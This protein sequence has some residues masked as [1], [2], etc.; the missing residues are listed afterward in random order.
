ME[1]SARTT[2]IGRGLAVL[3][4]AA[5][6]AL[7][8]EQ[9]GSPLAAALREGRPCLGWLA[10]ERPGTGKPPALVLAVYQPLRRSLDLVYIP[11]DIRTEAGRTLDQVYAAALKEGGPDAA[12]RMADSAGTFLAPA[13][14][15]WKDWQGLPL[16]SGDCPGSCSEPPL[17]ARDWLLVRMGA[18]TWP[19]LLRTARPG[20]RAASPW[21]R[22]DRLLLA[23]ELSRLKPASL[24]PA[25]LPAQERLGAL[26][27]RCLR[28]AAGEEGGGHVTVE[29]LNA[30]AKTGIA[31]RAKNIL[32]L[33][34]AD[35]MSVGNAD[36]APARTVVFDRVGRFE[37]AAA[38]ARMLGCPAA[39]AATQVD[40]KRLVDV[41][42]VLTDDC[43]L[44]QGGRTW[45]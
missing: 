9:R 12:R 30:S 45:N 5:A 36:G 6:L 11:G 41:T 44:P 1:Q 32:R 42:V 7:G 2:L 31:S 13:A 33:E 23:W 19:H 3:L 10:L 25:W 27:G 28:P 18:R 39:V 24:R 14:P 21:P 22:V 17:D 15:A 4:V 8:W 34:G 29:V 26:L 38:V 43:P 40:L 20:G 35:V 37:N 16:W